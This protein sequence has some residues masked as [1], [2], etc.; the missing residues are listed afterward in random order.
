MQILLSKKDYRRIAFEAAKEN[1]LAA[2]AL[3]EVFRRVIRDYVYAPEEAVNGPD[4]GG[5]DNAVLLDLP[6][7]EDALAKR[8]RG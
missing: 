3:K 6:H 5:A 7:I 2:R 8:Q 4:M 1:R